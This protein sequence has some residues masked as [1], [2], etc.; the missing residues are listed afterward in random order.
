[1]A[2]RLRAGAGPEAHGAAVDFRH[3]G[4]GHRSAGASPARVTSGKPM[5]RQTL[6]QNVRWQ[7]GPRRQTG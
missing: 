7:E 2:T 5:A 1:M 6:V 3:G 4:T